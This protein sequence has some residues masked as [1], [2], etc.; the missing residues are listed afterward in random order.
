MS[1]ID[2][3]DLVPTGGRTPTTTD[4]DEQGWTEQSTIAFDREYWTDTVWRNR[5]PEHL[6][7]GIAVAQI[8]MYSS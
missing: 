3:H 7:D 4:S 1:A 5:L 8:S 6:K 2:D